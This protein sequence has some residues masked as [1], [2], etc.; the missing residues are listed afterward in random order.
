MAGQEWAQGQLEASD[1]NVAGRCARRV[2]DAVPDLRISDLV[3]AAW[4]SADYRCPDI[5]L[6][7]RLLTTSA[8]AERSRTAHHNV[9]E[10]LAAE[11]LRHK[12]LLE[13]LRGTAIRFLIEN[14]THGIADSMLRNARH[15]VGSRRP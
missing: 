6:P 12:H 2:A 11:E 1:G 14:R 9:F 15:P 13:D 7:R 5:P 3:A 8:M 4:T 10:M